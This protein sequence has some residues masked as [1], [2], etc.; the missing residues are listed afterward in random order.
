MNAEQEAAFDLRGSAVSRALWPGTVKI[1]GVE[2][3][4]AVVPQSVQLDFGAAGIQSVAG[5]RVEIPKTALADCPAVEVPLW[6]GGKTY[7]I[8][9]TGGFGASDA[10]WYLVCAQF[11]K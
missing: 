11:S 10:D 9:E 1:A 2:Y 7:T 8:K 3:A 4:A 5:V 6:T